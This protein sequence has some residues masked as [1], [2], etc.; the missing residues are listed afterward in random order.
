M[1]KSVQYAIL[2]LIAVLVLAAVLTR[3]TGP[4]ASATPKAPTD[5]IAAGPEPGSGEVPAA[6][7]PDE[8]S[9]AAPSDGESASGQL[10]RFVEVGAQSCVPCK[11]MQPIL[12]ELR[13]DHAGRLQVDFRHIGYWP[14]EEIDAKLKE[15]GIIG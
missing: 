10:P 14:R 2:V 9:P 5:V 15:L 4:R 12:D 3:D 13:A 1:D 6:G 11:M 7:E 8:A